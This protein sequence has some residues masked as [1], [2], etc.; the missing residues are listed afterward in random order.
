M[1]SMLAMNKIGCLG[2]MGIILPT[3]VGNFMNLNK[4]Q[5]SMMTHGK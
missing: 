3:Y 1:V 2:Y 5:A 4:D